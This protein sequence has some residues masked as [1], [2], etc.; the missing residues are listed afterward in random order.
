MGQ[1][2]SMHGD[3]M[4]G[5]MDYKFNDQWMASAEKEAVMAVPS[6]MHALAVTPLLWSAVETCM[7]RK[8]EGDHRYSESVTPARSY[9]HPALVFDAIRDELMRDT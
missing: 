5:N 2:L 4:E 8:Q 1:A 7:R 3:S 6:Y 9:M